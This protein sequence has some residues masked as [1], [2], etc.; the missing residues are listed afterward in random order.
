M[1]WSNATSAVVRV[2]IRVENWNGW[3]GVC[4]FD[5]SLHYFQCPD[6]VFEDNDGCSS[7][8]TLTAGTYNSLSIAAGDRDFY[9][10]NVPAGMQLTLLETL[11]ANSNID[12]SLSGTGC[13]SASGSADT[14]LHWTNDTG[15]PLDV[16]LKALF[17][18]Q[19]DALCAPYD[20]D[21]SFAPDPCLIVLDDGMEGNDD[22]ATA[23]AVADGIYADLNVSILD[24]DHY[25]FN[26]RN[27]AA[28]SIDI[29]PG[30]HGSG[31]D[32]FL[33]SASS[34]YCGT[35]FNGALNLLAFALTDQ[36]QATLTWTNITGTDMDVVFEV[37][38][39]S[40]EGS[41]CNTYDLVLTGSGDSGAGTIGPAFC[42]PMDVNS[43]G[44]STRPSGFWGTG[45]GSDL[46]LEATS[47][48]PAQFG[49]FLVSTGATDPGLAISQ[50]RLCLDFLGGNAFGRLAGNCLQSTPCSP[51]R[52]TWLPPALPKLPAWNS[53]PPSLAVGRPLL[54]EPRS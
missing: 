18:F 17:H 38:A 1:S 2:I 51:P 47:G 50:G 10:I 46:H 27:G 48:P 11:D 7:A 22:C 52:P 29:L 35:G 25:A 34:P 36:D 26:V 44:A 31:V 20:I 8:A 39:R 40:L 16:S 5:I 45:V 13:S 23:S 32:G 43:T 19:G 6:D 9:T 30:N 28:I 24:E 53:Y 14:S 49:Y 33:R 42:S 4:D 15:A 12:W 3:G 21:L 41:S 37:N 54:E